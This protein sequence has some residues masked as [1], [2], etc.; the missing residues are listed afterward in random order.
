[1]KA[2]KKQSPQ[3]VKSSKPVPAKTVKAETLESILKRDK[4]FEYTENGKLKCKLTNHEM[5]ATIENYKAHISSKSYRRAQESQFNIEEYQAILVDHKGDPKFLYCKITGFKIP[6]KKSAIDKH[7][8][9][10][11]F[12]K[13]L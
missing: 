11:R 3:P 12:K 1:M 13:A 8:Q 4:N 10:K 6:K 2:Q 5:P 7:V 9:G